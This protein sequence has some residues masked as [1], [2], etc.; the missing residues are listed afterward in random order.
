MMSIVLS[1]E[2]RDGEIGTWGIGGLIP[3]AAVRLARAMH[4]PN[5]TIGGERVYDSNPTELAPGLDDPR[6]MENAVGIEGFW[7]LFG[8]WHKGLDFFYFS[9]M[10]VDPYGNLNLHKVKRDDGT[11]LR[12]PGVANISLAGSCRRTFLYMTSHS[13]RKFVEELDFRSLPGHLEGGDS[14][15]ASGLTG[16]GPAL[17]V[18]PIAVFDFPAPSRRM[19]LLSVHGGASVDD[20]RQNT[21]F[22]FDVADDISQTDEPTTRE[23]EVLRG[24]VDPSGALRSA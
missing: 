21:G 14:R 13:R 17:C 23:I 15:V 4:A 11:F 22:E 1:R 20:V 9:G 18:T 2:L 16:G 10:Q 8:H 24:E 7:E 19:R 3:M 6:L 12:G 5:L